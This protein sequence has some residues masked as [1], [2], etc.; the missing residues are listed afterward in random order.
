MSE[1]RGAGVKEEKSPGDQRE[2]SLEA[3]SR[4]LIAAFCGSA[5]YY[6]LQSHEPFGWLWAVLLAGGGI[7]ALFKKW[8]VL[9]ISLAAGGIAAWFI[10][11]SGVLD[12]P[13]AAMTI[14]MLLRMLGAVVVPLIALY[15]GVAITDWD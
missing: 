15:I 1:P 11:P 3:V 8:S 9:V 7:V 5:A 4:L 6:A 2:Q 10:W 12:T 13:L 14:G